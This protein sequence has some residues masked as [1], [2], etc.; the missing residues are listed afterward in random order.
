[1]GAVTPSAAASDRTDPRTARSLERLTEALRGMLSEEDL[2]AVTVSALCR[3]A[4]VHRTT[5]YGHFSSVSELAAEVY[6]D[7]VGVAST[8]Q[9]PENADATDAA[10]IF[11]AALLDTLYSVA[12]ERTAYRALFGAAISIGI[13]RRLLASFTEHARSAILELRVRGTARDVDLDSA[14]TFIAGGMVATVERWA[15]SD[16]D[17]ADAFARDVHE[18]LPRWWPRLGG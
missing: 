3:R 10:R 7:L 5:F 13:R 8:V 12:R 14:A 6:T 18:Q 9:I 17:D 4:G 11:H 15:L 16:E 2:G 1:M